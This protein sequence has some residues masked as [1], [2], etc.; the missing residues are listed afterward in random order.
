MFF[1]IG[2]KLYSAF[3]MP[4]QRVSV[5]TEYVDIAKQVAEKI[6]WNT[7]VCGIDIEYSV[8]T[9]AQNSRVMLALSGGLDSVYL[10]HKLIDDGYNVTAVH[11]AGLNKSSSA[12]EEISARA[13][14]KKAGEKYAKAVY[15]APRQVFPDNPFKNQLILSIL[16]DIGVKQGIYRYAIGSDWTTPL[17]EAAVGYT[18]TDSAEVN[19]AFWS[20]IKARF[21]QAELLFIPNDEKKYKRLEYLWDKNALQDVSSC[22]SPHRFRAHLHKQNIEKYGVELMPGRC[23]SC[24]KCAMEYLL[25]VHMGKI[26]KDERFAEHSWNTLATSQT[27]HRPDLF[28]KNMPLEQRI[29]NLINYG[30]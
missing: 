24:Y 15:K 11:I 22:I 2:Q 3:L 29:T 25:L 7:E 16:L 10:M 26:K 5:P 12:D 8:S 17:N 23:G 30:S 4:A 13:A 19:Q 1:E 6:G 21:P 20:G 18:I 14:A 27:A 9:E 28:A